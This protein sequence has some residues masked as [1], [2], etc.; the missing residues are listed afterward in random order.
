MLLK[1]KELT[2]L[3]KYAEKE[4]NNKIEK[5]KFFSLDT[6]TNEIDKIQ[7][8]YENEDYTFF[9]DLAD[10]VIFENISEE[11]R[12]DFSS[13]DHNEN[14]LELAKFITQDYIIKLK[15]LIKNNYVVLDSEKNTFEQIERI[16]LIKEK[17]YLTS[18][19]VSLIYQIKKDKLLDLRTKKMLK[20]FQ[21]EDNAKVLFNKKDIEEFMRKYTF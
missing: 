9:A 6:I 2:K 1:K 7:E 8:S 3:K 4:L 10:S 17:K 16:N 11:Y 15:I 21:I 5:V 14:I 20:Y 13:E 18:E 19:E 12:D